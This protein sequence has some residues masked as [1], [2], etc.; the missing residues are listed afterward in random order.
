MVAAASQSVT[1]VGQVS[2]AG[3]RTVIYRHD[4]KGRIT[5]WSTENPVPQ[6]EDRGNVLYDCPD[7]G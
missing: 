1:G 5:G 2:P 4:A 3:T 6:A 7:A